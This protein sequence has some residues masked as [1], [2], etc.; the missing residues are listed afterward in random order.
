MLSG[1]DLM[2]PYAVIFDL[3]GVLIDSSRVM[4][5]AFEYAYREFFPGGSAPFD[6]YRKHMGK[7]FPA[8]MDAMGLPRAMFKPFKARSIELVDDVEVFVGVHE[9]LEKLAA[10]AIYIGI[11][12]G[13]DAART[14]QIL[15]RKNLDGYFHHVV[16][17]DEVKHGKPHPESIEVHLRLSRAQPWHTFFVGD[18]RADI[19]C[20]HR[21]GVRSVAA[22][23]GMG[24]E[25]DLRALS[26][27]YVIQELG[28]LYPLI[29]ESA[30]EAGAHPEQRASARS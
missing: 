10:Q 7:G 21:A 3:D 23:W 2:A 11:A 1:S 24:R 29:C 26:P 22:L 14:R 19:E 27:T 25:E 5:I 20:A 9:L 18:A 15:Q 4:Q 13:K 6:E 16:S 12:T 17:S 30:L 8:I 28:D